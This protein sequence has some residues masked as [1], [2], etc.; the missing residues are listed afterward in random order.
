MNYFILFIPI[1]KEKS[2]FY[3]KKK[4]TLLPSELFKK[5]RVNRIP[6]KFCDSIESNKKDAMLL[7]PYPLEDSFLLLF[8]N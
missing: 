5:R 7:F 1:E 2:F 3:E 8:R 4:M 6:N